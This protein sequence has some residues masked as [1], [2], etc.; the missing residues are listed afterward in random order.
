MLTY[1][2]VDRPP[3]GQLLFWTHYIFSDLA[4]IFMA[5]DLCHLGWKLVLSRYFVAAE[6]EEM[7]T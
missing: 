4:V 3:L 2:L 5:D 6:I 1:A 7:I